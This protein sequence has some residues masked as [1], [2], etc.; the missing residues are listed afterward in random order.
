MAKKCYVGVNGIAKNVKKMYV[1]VN[2]V[3][4]K[5]LKGYV[6]VNGVPKLFF[7]GQE[8]DGLVFTV[9]VNIRNHNTSDV[10]FSDALID[11]NSYY[12]EHKPLSQAGLVYLQYC[13]SILNIGRTVISSPTLTTVDVSPSKS[14]VIFEG[15]FNA[16][17]TEFFMGQNTNG[18]YIYWRV[19]NISFSAGDTYSFAVDVEVRQTN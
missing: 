9:F 10:D 19:T 7:D 1:G 18:N 2:G 3:P 15:T 5:V 16:S 8:F 6:G 12:S 14:T 13:R 11:V 4:K 17:G